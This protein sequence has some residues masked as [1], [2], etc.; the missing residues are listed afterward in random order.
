MT[1]FSPIS[2]TGSSTRFVGLT[3]KLER[4]ADPGHRRC[5][6]YVTIGSS[7]GIH[8]NALIC[9][10]CGKNRGWI[11]SRTID[12]T[13]ETRARFGAPEVIT[14]RTP[15]GPQAQVAGRTTPQRPE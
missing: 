9:N 2:T 13:N 6:P 11:S 12:F 5:S 1:I 4:L 8:D 14:L 10:S 15:R 3:L 7:K